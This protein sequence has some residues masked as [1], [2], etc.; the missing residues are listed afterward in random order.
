VSGLGIRSFV[1]Q[2]LRRVGWEVQRTRN[3]SN[4]RQILRHLLRLTG[5]DTVL[6]VGA[7]IGQFGDL[8]LDVGFDGTLVSFEAIPLVHQQLVRHASRAS[9]SWLVAPCA[10]IGSR[11]GQIDINLSANTV[12][13]SVLPMREIHVASAPQS[14]Y[15]GKTT[16]NIE[17]LDELA[18]QFIAPKGTLLIKVDTQGY[19]MEV[20]RGATGLWPRTV[21]LQLE[22]SLVRLYEQA[23]S[24]LDMLAFTA[25]TGFELFGIVPG[26][27]DVNTGRMLQVDGFF[28]RTDSA[29][30]TDASGRNPLVGTI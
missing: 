3:A 5:V 9:K 19:E 22:L 21:A 13:S 8:L 12:S 14:R 29:L 23:P 24:L 26:F 20:L 1:Q 6:D 28:V 16:V 27:R 10:A 7:N 25:E 4:E 18:A 2:L 30:G 17:R 11:R 15:V